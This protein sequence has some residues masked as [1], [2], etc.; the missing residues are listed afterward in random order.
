MLEK[1][2][3][4]GKANFRERIKADFR[5]YKLVLCQKAICVHRLNCHNSGET[6]E[7]GEFHDIAKKYGCLVAPVVYRYL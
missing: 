4:M 5:L 7:V 1:W 2:G 6:E 3:G